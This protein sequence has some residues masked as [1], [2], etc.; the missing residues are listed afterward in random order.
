MCQCRLTLRFWVNTLG[1]KV[2]VAITLV[3]MV[4]MSVATWAQTPL[5]WESMPT[6]YTI[7]C[8]TTYTLTATAAEADKTV[9]FSPSSSSCQLRITC[10]AS[11]LKGSANR[12]Q[13]DL[14]GGATGRTYTNNTTPLWHYAGTYS[15]NTGSNLTIAFDRKSKMQ[16]GS[17][18]TATIECYCPC[19]SR[20]GS[21]SFASPSLNTTVGGHVTQT[22]SNECTPNNGTITYS[23]SDE[24][25]ATVNT[26]TGEVTGVREGTAT[27]TA[28]LSEATVSGTTYCASSTT[29]TVNVNACGYTPYTIGTGTETSYYYGPVNDWYN[30]G[31]RQ[32]IYDKSELCSGTIYSMAFQYAYSS[33]MTAKGSNISVYM[34]ETDKTSFTDEND[35]I[36]SG[37]LTLV[38]SGGMN[39]STGWNWFALDT[40]FEYTGEGNLVM[41]ILD[42]SGSYNNSY[43]TF[44]YT[45]A[46][47]N[48]QINFYADY[49]TPSM[50]TPPTANQ[51]T[52]NRPNTKFCIQCCSPRTSGNLSF[53]E[54]YREIMVDATTTQ[55]V[56][57]S[58]TPSGGTITYSSSDDAIAEVTNSGVVTG[59]APGYATITATLSEY[60]DGSKNWCAVTA[61]W[62]VKVKCAD[63]SVS[64]DGGCSETV[65]G[66]CYIDRCAPALGGGTPTSVTLGVETDITPS[67]YSWIWNAHD[68]AGNH[69]SS[70]STV[71]V[72]LNGYATAAQQQR[73][74]DVSVTV[75]DG[76]CEATAQAR[77][78]VSAGI[79]P[80]SDALP[81][82]NLGEI[83]VGTEG[84]IVI[85]TGAGSDLQ[86]EEPAVHIEASLGH[87]NLTFIP[88]GP[89]CDEHCY[90]DTVTF[91]DFAPSA[92]VTSADDIR[93]LR[94]N[95]EHS[96]IGDIQIKL[97]CPSNRSTIILQDYY[98]TNRDAEDDYSYTWPYPSE[99]GLYYVSFG[100]PNLTDGTTSSTYCTEADNPSGTGANYVWS[101]YGD[102]SYASGSGYVYEVANI[103]TDG[104]PRPYYV[105][106]T[107]MSSGE[108]SSQVYHPFQGFDN[109][110][111]CP[112]NGNWIVQVC[113]S[114]EADN[115]WI[116]EWEL[117]LSEDKLPLS[118][119]FDVTLEDRGLSCTGDVHT[120]QEVDTLWVRP[121]WG[122]EASG[123]QLVLTDNFGCQ[124]TV[125]N[126]I[127]FT[128]DSAWVNLTSGTPNQSY[129]Y[130][131]GSMSVPI[132]YTYG[133]KAT[134]VT[135]QWKKDGSEIGTYTSGTN[136]TNG[137]TTT[138]TSTGTYSGTVNIS[139][140]PSAPGLY[141]CDIWTTQGEPCVSNHKYDTIR[142]WPRPTVNAGDDQLICNGSP[143][144]VTLEASGSGGSGTLTYTWS[145]GDSGSSITVTPTETTTYEVTVSDS[146][147]SA[148][149]QV[150][151]SVSNLD[152]EISITP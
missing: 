98:N 22:A 150:Q 64:V 100:T 138:I 131:V 134:G 4:A 36:A 71:T 139:G 133:G 96:F 55:T 31:Y 72:P 75:S 83:C 99:N 12:D 6:S 13:I 52:A 63:V 23:S 62:T 80:A 137:I 145:N 9:V 148:T 85:G 146:H 34:G 78:R 65:D 37:S 7:T 66:V 32:I 123:C 102:Y 127:N 151:V 111:G 48:K 129:C 44:Y 39:C 70:G 60:N 116:F 124:T 30:Y 119:G 101:N 50:A 112:L 21:L 114:W 45:A 130:G 67:S 136:T 5:A 41:A 77:I 1:R 147:C 87:G 26:S 109:L 86:I 107:T 110:I 54:A 149:D 73:G 97:I 25:V 141:T 118:W 143:S 20:T 120:V 144:S 68:N 53:A 10:K 47:E 126:H 104:D 122:D 38:Y 89:N 14:S 19:T 132:Q 43:Y 51:I 46:S 29:Y 57:N 76:T 56:T 95:M 35:W 115:G 113:D 42:L 28:T 140:T 61:S 11:N 135:V 2:A 69:E 33:T 17:T 81:D 105:M 88:D 40:P 58:L 49:D 125:N 16:D 142:V 128:L 8:G 121:Q 152:A 24:S 93:F 108:P 79:R 18:W 74:Y 106:P 3:M 15:T 92:T 59:R 91:N 90:R 117:K 82:I 27:I 103:G 84:K 94:I